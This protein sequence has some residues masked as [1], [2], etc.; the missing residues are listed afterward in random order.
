MPETWL[1]GT[2]HIS[3]AAN[4]EI[5]RHFLATFVQRP[6]AT[7]V[8]DADTPQLLAEVLRILNTRK[9]LDSEA[10]AALKAVHMLLRDLP[11]T[12][13]LRESLQQRCLDLC[14]RAGLQF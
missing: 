7:P 11:A 3:A 14:R 8:A 12:E 9:L 2:H 13:P 10:Q 5:L 1:G 6:G 4:S